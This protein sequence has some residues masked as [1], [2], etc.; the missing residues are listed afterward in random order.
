MHFQIFSSKT[1]FVPA[2]VQF[3]SRTLRH[4]LCAAVRK[5]HHVG[6]CWILVDFEIELARDGQQVVE[7]IGLY[8]FIID[9]GFV[10][11]KS[12]DFQWQSTHRGSQL[13]DHE[14]HLGM[15]LGMGLQVSNRVGSKSTD[16]GH[17]P[18]VE[19]SPDLVAQLGIVLFD[20]PPFS[21]YVVRE[22]ANPSKPHQHLRCTEPNRVHVD[23]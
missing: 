11:A 18:G 19:R 20:L 10:P 21:R 23:V 13:T 6:A 3:R 8:A 22:V 14:R 7:D 17:T 5:P 1:L 9:P 15:D 4:N 16:I 2:S 12:V